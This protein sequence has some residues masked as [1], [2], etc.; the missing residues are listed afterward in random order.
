MFKVGDYVVYGNTGVCKIEDIGPLSIGSSDKEYYTLVPVYGRNSKLYT[1][2]DSDK[3]VIRPIMTKQESDALINEMEEIDALRIG[4]EKR[5]EEIYKETM[6]TCDCKEW[7]RIIKTLYSRKMD[8]LS[9]GKKVT[10]SDER[11][12]QM[13]EENL[14]GELAFSLQMPKEKVGEFIGEKIGKKLTMMG[15]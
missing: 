15:I 7:V 1:A 5:R 10:S 11:Y 9:R 6:R 8:R 3:V 14:F 13:A 12:L 2:V 4:D